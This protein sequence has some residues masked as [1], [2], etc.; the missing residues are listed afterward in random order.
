MHQSAYDHMALCVKLYMSDDR[1]Y[2]VIDLGARLSPG[3]KLTHRQMLADRDVEYYGIDVQ[4][5]KNVDFVMTKPY[6][7]P[8]PS[9]ST[10]I[11][12]SG[13]VFEHIPFFWA[14]MLEIARILR[15]KG[16]A[17][18]TAPSRGHRHSTY[19]CWRYYPDGYRA[20][21]AFAA[22]EL[23]E[24][25]TDFPPRDGRRHDFAAIDPDKS[26]WGDSV[27]V[28]QKPERYPRTR[29][30]IVRLATRWWANRVGDLEGTPTPES[31]PER[32]DV[33]A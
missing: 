13:Q 30:G 18:I 11:V 19:D 22:L 31:L 20:M 2:R 21:G 6:R 23:R 10:D 8:V 29:A 17:F 4:Q 32:R 5:G 33:T 25:H 12:I 14:S 16:Y 27:G 24:V 9:N 26:Y 3:Q 1:R 28:F 7:L 15:P